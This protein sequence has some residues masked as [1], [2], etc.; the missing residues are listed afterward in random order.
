MNTS[1]EASES[2]EQKL[3]LILKYYSSKSS[4]KY[5]AYHGL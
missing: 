4:I 2:Q 1:R 5:L 3:I